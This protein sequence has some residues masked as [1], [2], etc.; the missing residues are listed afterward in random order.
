MVLEHLGVR[1]KRYKLVYFYTVDEWELYD[2][3]TN[4]QEQ[5]NFIHSATLQ[6][7]PLKMS[8]ELFRLQNLYDDHEP[9]V[10]FN[11][12]ISYHA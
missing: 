1:G 12:P 2:L 6:K 11:Y 5:K 8:E 3:T 10:F 4:P 7:V 9:A